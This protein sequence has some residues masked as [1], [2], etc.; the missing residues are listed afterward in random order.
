LRTLHPVGLSGHFKPLG[1]GQR[2]RHRRPVRLTDATRATVWTAAYDP[3]GQPWQITGA[4]GQNLRFP[5]QY[6]LLE[7]GL[8]YN[9]HRVYDASTGRYTQPDPLRFVDGPSVYGYATASPMMRVD[10]E[11][12][13]VRIPI[14]GIPPIGPGP[15]PG[16]KPGPDWKPGLKPRWPV[17]PPGLIEYFWNGCEWI[18]SQMSGKDK[19][20][21]VEGPPGEWV[22]G[23]RRS[24]QY[25]PDGRP[26]RD[27][28][29]P[30]QGAPDP[31]V[32]EWENGIRE[33]P[34]RPVTPW[35]KKD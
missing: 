31:H 33:H 30:H 15:Y 28:D 11:G 32:H 5:G 14:P 10:P 26:V 2:R 17:Q 27:I 16:N 18:V 4:V 20:V 12:Q 29:K 19:D 21:P 13:Q 8:S 22:D 25:G 1:A 35:P 9:W 24:R 7:S 3:F 34:G 23:K 6:F